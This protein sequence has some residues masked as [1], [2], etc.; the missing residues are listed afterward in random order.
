MTLPLLAQSILSLSDVSNVP[1]RV[2]AWSEEWP[3]EWPTWQAMLPK[4][5]D[6]LC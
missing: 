6:E 2:D 1:N 5:L 4:Y 3:H